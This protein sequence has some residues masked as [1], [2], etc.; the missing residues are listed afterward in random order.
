MRVYELM[1]A[2]A[3]MPAAASVSFQR[4]ATKDELPK[5]CNDPTLTELAFTIREVTEGN[6]YNGN[7]KV[8]LDGWAE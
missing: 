1:A 5:Y 7:P 6:D 8:I 4:L 2:L 3:T